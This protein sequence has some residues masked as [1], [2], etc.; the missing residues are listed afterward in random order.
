MTKKG[1]LLSLTTACSVIAIGATVFMSSGIAETIVFANGNKTQYQYT[2]NDW[3]YSSRTGQFEYSD[4][5]FCD[6]FI[7]KPSTGRQ[8]IDLVVLI[9]SLN[10]Q[11]VSPTV[12]SLTFAHYEENQKDYVELYSERE[13]Y[14]DEHTHYHYEDYVDN[15]YAFYA[16]KM[17][18]LLCKNFHTYD[19]ESSHTVA[20][21]DAL[22]N[23]SNYSVSFGSS[24]VY[25]Y[26][27]APGASSEIHTERA[28]NDNY[29]VRTF[30]SI[31]NYV[32]VPGPEENHTGAY[33]MNKKVGMKVNISSISLSYGCEN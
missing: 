4:A 12:E 32:D 19:D 3:N 23:F 1:L 22:D 33:G 17:I 21:Y 18:V 6:G 29:A 5:E 2:L 25:N 15:V 14:E 16:D 7:F 27:A 8:D 11:E 24:F 10:Y 9:K 28:H 20:S 30:T 26:M 13:F 31:N